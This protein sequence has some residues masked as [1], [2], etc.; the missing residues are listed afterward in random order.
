MFAFPHV[1]DDFQA[2]Q[3]AVP[4]FNRVK[5]AGNDAMDMGAGRKCLVSHGAHQPNPA[6]SVNDIQTGRAQ[7][8]SKAAGGLVIGLSKR[9]A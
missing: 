8:L 9:I 1:V 5:K 2:T 4:M 6:T 3:L 7:N